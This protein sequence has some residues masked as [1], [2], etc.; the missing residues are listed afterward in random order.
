MY[1]CVVVYMYLYIYAYAHI[2]EYIYTFFFP[3]GWRRGQTDLPVAELRIF[4]VVPNVAG[5][6][7]Q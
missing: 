3:V 2:S 1:M 6:L 4:S 5:G 7:L